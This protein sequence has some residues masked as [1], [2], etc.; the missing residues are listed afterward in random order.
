MASYEDHFEIQTA[1][2]DLVFIQNSSSNPPCSLVEKATA[3]FP[4]GCLTASFPFHFNSMGCFCCFHVIGP[5]CEPRALINPLL[6][7]KRYHTSIIDA[8]DCC[9]LEVSLR[10]SS[11]ESLVCPPP[12][13]L[14]C[15]SSSSSVTLDC[16]RRV[17]SF[18]ISS[19]SP[20]PAFG[21]GGGVFSGLCIDDGVKKK[22]RPSP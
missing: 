7:L 5:A 10:S 1:V 11:H 8:A 3:H 2:T 14:R 12:P 19:L 4:H 21:P 17:A 20:S 13:L 6:P 15:V 22:M 16:T 18:I 9:H